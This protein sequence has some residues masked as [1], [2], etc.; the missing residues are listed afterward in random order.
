M[1]S[2]NNPLEDL[3]IPLLS[4]TNLDYINL[5]NS[6]EDTNHDMKTVIKLIEVR[7]PKIVTSSQYNK[8]IDK[9]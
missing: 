6:L 1:S 8:V 7:N 9:L 4:K 2:V 5:K 3:V